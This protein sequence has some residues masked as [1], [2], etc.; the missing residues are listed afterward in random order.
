[1]YSM[2][3]VRTKAVQSIRGPLC[4]AW[5]LDDVV[6]QALTLLMI[7]KG[8]GSD[9][10]DRHETNSAVARASQLRCRH[11]V[12]LTLHFKVKNVQ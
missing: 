4:L 8:Q 2:L 10:T 12:R 9:I 5:R 3:G 7:E 11:K 1:M 6:L